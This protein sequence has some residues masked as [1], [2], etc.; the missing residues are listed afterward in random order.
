ARSDRPC[1][2]IRTPRPHRRRLH[3]TSREY[4]LARER[5]TAAGGLVPRSGL[6]VRPV[7][8]CG[9]S[10]VELVAG[11][12]PLPG[13]RIRVVVPP[14]FGAGYRTALPSRPDGSEDSYDDIRLLGRAVLR[15]KTNLR[16]FRRTA[17]ENPP[18]SRR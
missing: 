9:V 13:S 2:G 15:F 7:A 18:T 12:G 16:A 6:Q 14:P 3:R 11:T 10:A 17:V 4:R 5:G 1:A 8:G